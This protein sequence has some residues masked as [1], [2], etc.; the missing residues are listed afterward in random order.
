MTDNVLRSGV[1][2]AVL[3]TRSMY[4][5][6]LTP[7]FH[8]NDL[9]TPAS[10]GPVGVACEAT[11]SSDLNV[12]VILRVVTGRGW[13]VGWREGLVRICIASLTQGSSGS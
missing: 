2:R 13:S 10:A 4:V 1:T 5:S 12:S 8:G 3:G 7:T 9:V 11:R 6:N